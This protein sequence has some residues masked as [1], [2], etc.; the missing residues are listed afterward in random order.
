MNEREEERERNKIGEEGRD[1]KKGI[2]KEKEKETCKR[3]D[4]DGIVRVPLHLLSL[5]LSL[6]LSSS[7][8]IKS[9][10]FFL[11][12]RF[13]LPSSCLPLSLAAAAAA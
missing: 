11:V 9:S 8:C 4:G 6:F 1:E 7:P 5:S 12:F 3:D 2:T 10:T 13:A